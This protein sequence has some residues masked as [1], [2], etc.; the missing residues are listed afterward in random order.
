MASI[1]SSGLRRGK[2]MMDSTGS[3]KH[4]SEVLEHGNDY[5]L[6]FKKFWSDVPTPDGG[7]E[8]VFDIAAGLVPGRDLNRDIFKS[9]FVRFKE[10]MFTVDEFDNVEDNTGLQS[11]AR[12]AMVLHNAQCAREIK[13]AEADAERGAQELG[14]PVDQGSLKRTVDGITLKYRGGE[15]ADGTRI[16]PKINPMISGIKKKLTTRVL[17]VKLD[18]NGVPIWNKAEYAVYEF[19]KTRLE[20]FFSVISKNEYTC[21]DRDYIEVG[22]SYQGA[23]KAAA[24][25]AAKFDGHVESMLLEVMYPNEWKKYG[26]KMVA[27]IV[28]D[29]AT[30]NSGEF[31]VARNRNLTSAKSPKEVESIMRLWCANNAAVFG[32]I[33]WEA[34]E[35]SKAAEDFLANHIVDNIPKALAKFTELAEENKKSKPQGTD[36]DDNDEQKALADAIDLVNAGATTSVK[37]AVE[38]NISNDLDDMELE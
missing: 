2:K 16:Y 18:S 37:Q 12:I 30:E 32:S 35:T 6:F 31:C 21:G 34:E 15:A 38:N 19:R 22:Y 9:G 33:D 20:E 1:L 17:V 8:R 23:D 7:I 14:L 27:E 25:R 24:G 4:L 29:S 10:G 13:N 3:D 26:E 5:V 36:D 28:P 11:W